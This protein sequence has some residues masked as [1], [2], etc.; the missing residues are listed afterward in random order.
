MSGDRKYKSVVQ[1]ILALLPKIS[2]GRGL[3][4]VSLLSLAGPSYKGS[5]F[6]R[7]Q[8]LPSGNPLTGRTIIQGTVLFVFAS[9]YSYKE[10]S[11][12]PVF[13]SKVS[14]PPIRL[15]LVPRASRLTLGWRTKLGPPLVCA[16]VRVS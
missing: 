8:I 3:S 5:Y 9:L 11:R 10:L 1:N 4:P 12:P 16:L 13:C 14:A 15:R 6:R 2:V 7:L